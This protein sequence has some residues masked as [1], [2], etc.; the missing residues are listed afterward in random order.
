MKYLLVLIGVFL[1]A[2]LQ[3]GEG[4]RITPPAVHT[5]Q[6][7]GVVVKDLSTGMDIASVSVERDSVPFLEAQVKVNGDRLGLIDTSG[8]YYLMAPELS[9]SLA[10]CSLSAFSEPDSYTIQGA[11]I[12]PGEFRIEYLWPESHIYH[13]GD[14]P[15][16]IEW[17]ISDS[18]RGYFI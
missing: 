17:S 2:S 11:A 8:I 15:P 14:T 7:E 4:K 5:F 1:L 6:V 10:P 13:S 16:H 3:C 12:M 18:A 9:P